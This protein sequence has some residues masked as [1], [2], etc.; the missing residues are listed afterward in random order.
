MRCFTR[1]VKDQESRYSQLSDFLMDVF[2]QSFVHFE[3]LEHGINLKGDWYPIIKMEWV[4]G[5]PLSKFVG[6]KLNE[7]D[8]LRRIAA[9]WRGGTTASLRGLRIAHNDLQHGNVMVQEDGNIRLVDY[10]GMFLPQFLGE[11]SP[12][13]GHKNYQ[14]PQRSAEDYDER[15][16]YFPSLVIYLSLLA[17]A[18]DPD[19]WPEFYNDD[20]LL[21]TRNDYADPGR[22]ELFH[23]LKQ[24][25][26][27]T[28]AGLAARLE[29]C[30]SLPVGQVPD[31]ETI[32]QGPP[33]APPPSP[34]PTTSRP[35]T[36]SP[37]LKLLQTGQASSVPSPVPTPTTV[38]ASAPID[39]AAFIQFCRGL[40]GCRLTKLSQRRI[41]WVK[42]TP[43]NIYFTPQSTG[44]AK[45]CSEHELRRFLD[46]F[47]KT[48]SW[49]AGAYSSVTNN[50]SY[51]LA[52][53]RHYLDSRSHTSPTPTQPTT[54]PAAGP[55]P[56]QPTTPPVTGPT[57]AQPTTPPVTGPTPAQPTTPPVTLPA[58]FLNK[59][60][61]MVFVLMAL[62]L[63]APYLIGGL[64]WSV[65]Q[66]RNGMP[67][68][69]SPT[70]EATIQL[71]T[72]AAGPVLPLATSTPTPAPTNTPIP[73]P[74]PT[75]TLI[76]TLAPTATPIPTPAPTATPIPTPAPTAT[77]TPEPTPM[78]TRFPTATPIPTATPA[79]PRSH[80]PTPVPR[81]L[82]DW[83]HYSNDKYGYMVPVPP[84]WTVDAGNVGAV[85]ITKPDGRASVSIIAHERAYPSFGAFTDDIANARRAELGDRFEMRE[86]WPVKGDPS[87]GH[88]TYCIKNSAGEYVS[89]V[90]GI[91]II[92]GGYG[93]E[94]VGQMSLKGPRCLGD[95][96]DIDKGIASALSHFSSW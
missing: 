12:E 35:T 2:P 56:A 11:P 1:E 24:S 26:D 83:W 13:L 15:I 58:G 34:S 64:V 3:Y 44:K 30:C 9:R 43:P 89:I 31:L 92:K 17:V 36:S 76:P 29:E 38:P 48:G 14:H 95:S 7:P 50:S 33:S 27:E 75:A 21:F 78:P 70:I 77:P 66:G 42:F 5:E 84:N 52:V 41:F 63:V 68:P 73:T 19:L 8:T 55:A 54:L 69:T 28:V 18:A 32:L 23:R 81:S 96:V 87:Q 49:K 4:E 45:L 6:S 86:Q 10:D 57:P 82:P 62:V 25:Q 94:L 37:Y 47:E 93:L 39:M 61:K 46:H 59:H 71:T 85:R 88:I 74:K 53:L 16:D 60:K 72:V 20:N 91:L 22:S 67:T 79:L 65:V 40:N 90:K 80:S 51:L